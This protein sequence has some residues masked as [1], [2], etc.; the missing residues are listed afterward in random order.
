ML[1]RLIAVLLIGP[2]LFIWGCPKDEDEETPTQHSI[3]VTSPNGGETWQVGSNHAVTW[4][5]SEISTVTIE[6]S[7]DGGTNWTEVVAGLANN[8]TYSWTLPNTPAIT[9]KVKVRD[10]GD[11]AVFDVSDANFT[12]IAE[13]ASDNASGSVRSDTSGVIETPAGARIVVPVGA[14]PRTQ[15]GAVG[16][17][18]FS[19]E[20]DN[21]A[22]VTPPSGETVATDV[23]RFG[24]EGFTLARPVSVTIPVLDAPNQTDVQMYRVNPTTGEAERYSAVYDPDNHTLTAQTYEFSL[25]FGSSRPAVNTANGCVHVVNNSLHW[26]VMC[27]DSFDLTYP[28]QDLQYMASYGNGGMW[29]PPGNIGFANESEFFM[30]QGTFWV[31]LRYHI[32]DIFGD[33]YLHDTASVVI[34]SAWNYWDNPVCSDEIITS[35]PSAYA[36]TGEC[37]CIPTP[38][39][40]VG[41]GDIQVT[42]TWHYAA[43][44]VDLDL[45]VMDPDS[46]WCYYGNLQTAS[47]GELDR[48]NWCS[49][50]QNGW[51]ENIYWTQPPP[52]GQYIVAVDW[53][54]TCGSDAVGSLSFNVRTV[55]RGTAQTYTQ[56]IQ[57]NEDMHEVTRFT[58]SGSSVVFQPPRSDVSWVHLPRPSKL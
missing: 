56:T 39:T 40:S 16:T 28:E 33:Y 54:S 38:T 43:P 10:A 50:Y 55:V 30:P 31:C 47:G 34:G 17:M 8:N 19:I 44:G 11:A 51:P 52:A 12:V 15:S 6:W 9:C 46:E 23:Y 49:N 42:L 41:T 25:W 32:E 45:W 7:V 2:A 37:V 4:T 36:D 14:V 5:S 20:R 57:E 21:A 48:D 24:P 53:Y 22:T 26:L 35:G 18:V 27:V 58:I 29:A 3:T 1:K 13:S